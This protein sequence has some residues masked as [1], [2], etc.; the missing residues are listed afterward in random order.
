[1]LVKRKLSEV[2][3]GS[4]VYYLNTSFV[5]RGCVDNLALLSSLDN[6]VHITL[7][8]DTEL[9]GESNMEALVNKLQ[10][11][12]EE[13]EGRLAD[14]LDRGNAQTS[15]DSV[16]I[17]Q[18]CLK[19]WFIERSIFDYFDYEAK[20]CDYDKDREVRNQK[21]LKIKKLLN[22]LTEAYYDIDP[23]IELPIPCVI[24]IAVEQVLEEE[25]TND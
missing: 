13:Y 19:T 3:K 17:L 25:C 20:Y 14:R 1:M 5:S 11:E 2:P 16:R 18:G 7:P 12:M 23:H 10:N 21:L 4:T 15:L 9:D 22:K 6:R 24:E 8:A